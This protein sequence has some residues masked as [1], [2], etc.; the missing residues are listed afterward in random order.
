MS[1]GQ[2]PAITKLDMADL[3]AGELKSPWGLSLR[4]QSVSSEQADEMLKQVAIATLLSF[5]RGA[6]NCL[7][8]INGLLPHGFR[9]TDAE[10]FLTKVWASV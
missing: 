9:F 3:E 1:A 7:D 10:E 8:E 6:W 5:T 2:A 4:H